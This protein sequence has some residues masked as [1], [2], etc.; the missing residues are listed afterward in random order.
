MSEKRT[1][2][3]K[4]E[5]IHSWNEFVRK[6]GSPPYN[7][8]AFRGHANGNWPLLSA[9]GRYLDTYI[10]EEYWERQEA[11]ILR[12]FQRK[13]HLYLT[14]PP[15]GEDRFQWLAL[16]QHHGGPTRLLDFTWSPYVA[17]FF[18]LERAEKEAAVWAL[19]PARLENVT[20]R[21]NQFLEAEGSGLIG[22]GEPFVMNKRLIA[23]SGTFIV[24]K[25]V[26]TPIESLVGNYEDPKDTLV[27]FELVRSLVRNDSM[28]ALFTMNITQA[29]LFPDLDGLARSLGYELEFNYG[30]DPRKRA[31]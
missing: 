2:P 14:N 10:E 22:I 24:T 13:A 6:V 9:L 1:V 15:P 8:W 7:S 21:L 11:R 16:M 23:Q 20:E 26:G 18:A 5:P 30:Y 4:I 3:Y 17:A 29:T 19:N 31:V 27:K 28:R 25:Q 12:I